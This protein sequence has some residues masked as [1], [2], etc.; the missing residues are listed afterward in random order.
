MLGVFLVSALP[1]MLGQ[2][3]SATP[4]PSPAI[5]PRTS[6]AV[7]DSEV[8]A[9][10]FAAVRAAARPSELLRASLRRPAVRGGSSRLYGSTTTYYA[11]QPNDYGSSLI[12]FR[13]DGRAHVSSRT[14]LATSAAEDVLAPTSSV[15]GTLIAVQADPFGENVVTV[16]SRGRRR[17]L[18]S[19]GHASF[20]LI[21][22]SRRVMFVTTNY[23]GEADG[24]AEID[25]NGRNRRT[26]YHERDINAVLS[27]PA[28]SPSGRTAYLVRNV[29]DRSGLPQSSLI[30]IDVRTGRTTSRPLPGLNYV[31]SVTASPNGRSLALVGYR[32]A[33]NQYARAFGFRGEADVL[34]VSSGAA[35]RV[36]W[37][38]QAFTVFSRG[39]SR[40]VVG[41][42]NRL[43]SVA[44]ASSHR[45][46]LFG[47]E[48]LALPVLAR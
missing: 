35:R 20:G 40:L 1:A 2:S 42:D 30:S 44:V 14:V 31:S 21:S 47:T 17:Q 22:P 6:I 46:P 18:T 27:L 8:L 39:S 10:G 24:L 25:F 13:T 5:S 16:D 23:N 45:D 12:R 37:V 7:N 28:M 11:L 29:F 9:R 48:G 26:I 15:G 33:D 41:A 19:D 32:A 43:V 34:G 38:D 4:A 36:A 3:A